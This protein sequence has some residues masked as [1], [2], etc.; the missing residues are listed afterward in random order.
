MI[1][2]FFYPQLRFN[3]SISQSPLFI[4]PFIRNVQVLYAFVAET[5]RKPAPGKRAEDLEK[6]KQLRDSTLVSAKYYHLGS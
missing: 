4:E 3:A 1:Y 5:G 6:L 2:L